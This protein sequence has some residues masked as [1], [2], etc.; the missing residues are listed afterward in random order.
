MQLTIEQRVKK[1]HIALMRHPETALYSGVFMLGESSVSDEAITAYTDGV[2]KKYGRAFVSALPDAEL[3]ALV[4]HENLHIAFRHMLHNRDLFEENSKLANIAADL[5]VNDVIVSLKD[6]TLCKLPPGGIVDPQYHNM[7]MREIYFK[8]RDKCKKPKNPEGQQGQ[9]GKPSAG[10]EEQSK[11]GNVPQGM[12]NYSFDEHDCKDGEDGK[13]MTSEEAKALDTKIDRALRE[14][15]LLAGRL[16]G[17]TPRA[18]RELLE[19]KTRWQD[20]LR[21]FVS[22]ATVGKD[23][24]TWRKFNRRLVANDIYMPSTENETIGE[25]VIAI[26]TS[27]SIGQEQLDEFG[28]ELQAICDSV[29]PEVVR[30]LWWDTMVHGE[31]I[32]RGKYEGIRGM[33]KPLGGGGTRVGCVA[34]HIEK[35]KIR[36]ECVVVFTDG[37]VESNPAWQIAAP[38]LW[39]VTLNKAWTP[40][41]G[42]KVVFES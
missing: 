1:S 18:I 7:N 22:A 35:T 28:A 37:F 8:L 33:L 21:E 30:I 32:F 42:R 16:G 38:T 9:Q 36:A 5:V 11:G 10:G 29:D 39:L 24:Y 23:E 34:E 31:Q 4:L 26:D 27:G 17:K 20:E 15:A 6:Q 25:V 13:P 41:V 3:N 40:P 2:N 12:E 14:G 19:P